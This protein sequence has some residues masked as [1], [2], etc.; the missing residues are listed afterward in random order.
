MTTTLH[1]P[2]PV[3][4][5]EAGV[6]LRASE[7]RARLLLAHRAA[8]ECVDALGLDD[9]RL[10]MRAAPWVTALTRAAYELS[11]VVRGEHPQRA[12]TCVPPV[13]RTR[14][15]AHAQDRL[16]MD[17]RHASVPVDLLEESAAQV[18]R[19]VRLVRE[20]QRS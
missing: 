8:A 13:V 14:E 9:L 4:G 18:A 7:A 6:D 2:R 5:P 17:L 12:A 20:C 3:A 15:L 10:W 19:L 16:V 11:A 1:D